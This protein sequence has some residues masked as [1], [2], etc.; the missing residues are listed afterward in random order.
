MILLRIT[1]LKITILITLK[2]LKQ[3]KLLIMTLLITDF[4]YKL[5]YNITINLKDVY[6]V[7]LIIVISEVISKV[8]YEYSCSVN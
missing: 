2:H 5:I 8:F 6:N 3:T 1:L 4:T 7:A